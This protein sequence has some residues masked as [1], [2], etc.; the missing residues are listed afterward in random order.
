MPKSSIKSEVTGI[1]LSPLTKQDV[2]KRAA[3][4]GVPTSS[5]IRVLVRIGLEQVDK[6]PSIL[7]KN[8]EKIGLSSS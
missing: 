7:L 8:S 5:F 4:L 6:D 3:I 1:R 2:A